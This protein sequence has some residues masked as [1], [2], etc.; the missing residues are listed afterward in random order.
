MSS[1]GRRFRIVLLCGVVLGGAA[2]VRAQD[3]Q[4]SPMSWDF[5]N[6]AVGSS[7]TVTF[8]LLAGW[9]TAVWVYVV[10]LNETAT[11][12]PPYANPNDPLTPSWSLGAFSFNPATYPA[13][14]VELPWKDYISVDVTFTP[15]APGSYEAYLFVF[16]NDSI[17]PPGMQAF[18]PLQ[19]T[20]VPAV[21]PAPGAILLAVVGAGL[22]G[23]LRRHRTL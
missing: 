10:S 6:V 18:F 5:G 20:A 19:G 16:S 2:L 23:W 15:P 17:P 21:V 12:V 8:D 11:D 22:V 13:L 7:A 9:P 4:P 3:L 1:A 14:P